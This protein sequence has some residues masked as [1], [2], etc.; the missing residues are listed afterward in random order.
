LASFTSST[1]SIGTHHLTVD[2]SGD[3]AFAAGSGVFDQVT[4]CPAMTVS[5]ATIPPAVPGVAYSQTFTQSG[6][7]G[8]IVFSLTGALP[9][10]MSFTAATA[11]LHG[12]ALAPGD[13]PITV[14]ATPANGC[15]AVSADYTLRVGAGGGSSNYSFATLAG[16]SSS[17]GVAD[18]TGSAAQFVSP[19][20]ASYFK[21]L[22]HVA[23]GTQLRTVTPAGVVQTLSTRVAPVR[24]V[25]LDQNGTAYIA[26]G[27][28]VGKVL[29]NGASSIVA[30]VESS[31]LPTGCG[32]ADGAAA[33]ARFQNPGGIAVTANGT[34]IFVADTANSTI[35]LVTADGATSTIAGAAG[36]PGTADAP[37]TAARFNAPTG[38]AL[39]AAGNLFV[40][41]TGNHT[42]RRMAPDGTV[43]TIA[44]LAG[45]AGAA[46]GTGT[47]ALFNSPTGLALGGDG[48]VYVADAGNSLLRRITADGVVTT[49]TGGTFNAAAGIAVDE[50]GTLYVGDTNNHLISQ[51]V[52]G[53]AVPPAIVA[54]PASAS[55]A[56][57]ATATFTVATSG[58]PVPGVQWEIST[59]GGLSWIPVTEAA[60]Y[61]GSRTPVLTITNVPGTL[62]GRMFRAV[63]ANTSGAVAS[64]MAL[65]TVDAIVVSPTSLRFAAVKD[66]AAG[67]L[68]VVTPAQDVAVDFS[69]SPSAWTATTDQPWLQLTAANGSG[70]GFFTV[71]VVNPNNVIDG[72]VSLTA[73]VTVTSASGLVSTIPVSLTVSLT[74]QPP[75]PPTP[76][77][78]P[79]PVPG[80]PAGVFDTPANLATGLQGSIPVTGWAIDDI[81]V[82]RVEIWRDPVP[83]EAVDPGPG[84]VQGKVFVGRAVFVAGARPDV[85]AIYPGYPRVESAGWG[86]LMLTYGLPN[87]GN[88]TYRL[89]AIAFDVDGV[90]ATILGAKTIG[91]DNAHADR[92]FGAIDTPGQG[93]TVTGTIQHFGWSLTPGATCSI[94]NPNVQVT[95]DSGPLVPVAYGD[96]R[97]DIAAFFPGYTN[98][99]AAGGHRAL[100]STALANGVHTIGWLVTDS[101]GRAEGIG[102]RFFTVSNGSSLIGSS[103]VMAP[104]PSARVQANARAW[105]LARNGAPAD[106]AIA[107]DGTRVARLAQ[108]ERIEVQLPGDALSP[109][110]TLPLGSSFDS[111]TGTFRWQPGAGFLGAYTL[112]FT[113]GSRVE[114][115]RVV[116]GPPIRIAIDAPAEGSTLGASGFTIAGWAADLASLAGAG[117]DTLH[118]WAY[119]A[120]GSPVFVGVARPGLARP[121]VARVYGESFAESGFTLTGSLPPGVYDLVVFAHSAATNRFEHAQ[122]VRVVVK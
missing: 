69:I 115:L 19:Q 5:P 122:S 113:A 66:G 39:D 105:A 86:Y 59:N 73:N 40:A 55:V 49:I 72:S 58:N 103:V 96:A 108:T 118:V 119:P 56:G 94:A 106:L 29:S 45:T 54:Q 53:A 70:R 37:G 120:S 18:G 92:P 88:G 93:A 34:A 13:F 100:D 14:T 50:V 1:F 47:A 52:L 15:G 81:G 67:A 22:V 16:S 30:G 7:A 111:A 21:G 104:R 42:I 121:D 61:Q 112:P 6:G 23:D 89:Y 64:Q 35:R 83:G 2:Y 77:P 41:D 43:T 76:T 3:S 28:A 102:S 82:D 9:G 46:D 48:S 25:A 8:T 24:A 114:T 79:T 20:G 38:L 62:N 36:Q 116:V 11:T 57:G 107:E 91:V 4:S 63:A 31:V 97:P 99:S 84:P 85:A 32:H 27:C 110:V 33:D 117:I 71:A 10:G 74:P 90:N 65:L 17:P 12:T 80:P 109:A 51:G 60:P 75:G 68:T 44:G 101:C 87:Q 95:V 98:A 78:P 26:V